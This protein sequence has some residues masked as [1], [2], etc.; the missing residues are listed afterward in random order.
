MN[1]EKLD[2]YL[3]RILEHLRDSPAPNKGVVAACLYSPTVDGCTYAIAE[4]KYGKWVHAERNAVRAFVSKYGEPDGRSIMLTTL[5]PCYHPFEGRFGSSCVDLLSGKDK[6]FKGIIV[7]RIHVGLVDPLQLNI[8]EYMQHGLVISVSRN[9]T[10]VR[11]CKS[12]F[13]YFRPETYGKADIPEFLEKAIDFG[14]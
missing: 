10:I 4:N 3:F 7:P 13:D 5:S 11:I 14:C 8:D 1:A 6:E 12:L 9:P 2:T